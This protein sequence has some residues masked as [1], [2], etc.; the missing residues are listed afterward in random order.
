MRMQYLNNP[1]VFQADADNAILQRIIDRRAPHG[2]V[3]LDLTIL[4][5]P[6]IA[7]G[8]N[9]FVKAIR[10]QNSLP[11]DYRELSFCSVAAFTGCWYEWE[12]HEPIALSVGVPQSTLSAIKSGEFLDQERDSSAAA[13][14]AVVEYASEMTTKSS[15]TED[16]FK[17]AKSFL[18]DVEMVELT[19]SI[20]GFNAICKFVV[21]LDV[22]EKNARRTGEQ[23][24]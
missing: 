12:I 4:H 14:V 6:Q 19:A 22:G 3:P 1:P 17:N 23:E 15:V 24:G 20:A 8:L 13:H 2:L 18:S 9:A 11:P 5:A 16:V 7:D 21:A 10:S